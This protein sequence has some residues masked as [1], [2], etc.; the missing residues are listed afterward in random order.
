[1]VVTDA[2]TLSTSLIVRDVSW[3]VVMLFVVV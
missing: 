1:M 2:H 3:C